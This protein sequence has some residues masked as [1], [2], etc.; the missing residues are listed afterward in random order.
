MRICGALLLALLYGFTAM[1]EESG[2]PPKIEPANPNLIPEAREV[3]D[4]LRLV[5]GTKTLAGINGF[6]NVEPIKA[7]CGKEPAICGFDLS[8]WNSPPWGPGYNKVV[9]SS[10]DSVKLWHAK[11]GIATMQCH[12]IH[13]SN[14]DGSAWLE[15]HGSKKPS[16]P[17][18]FA[19]ALKPGTKANQ[20]LMRDLKNH[21]DFL[22]QLK[23]AR[24]PVLWRPFHE[25]DGGWFW[26][27]DKENPENTAAAWRL[28]FDY[29]VKERKLDNLI[30]VYNCALRCGK[31]KEGI[32]NLE[33]RKRFYPGDPYVDIAGID[34]Y[35]SAYVGIG[36]PQEEAYAQSFATIRKLAPTKMVALSECEAT[37]DPDKIARDGPKWLYA[38]PWW[39][40]GKKHT[41]EWIKR[42]Y[43]HE[44]LITLDE[45]P[46]WKGTIQKA[47]E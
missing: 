46:K 8:G 18:A 20:E 17:F 28:M 35:P 16:Q 5:Y 30:W 2:P 32:E 36:T 41:E 21:A 1:G 31:G 45:L 10:I 23:E 9:Q 24:I 6:K 3:L 39:G 40:P 26:W 38:L 43:P 47:G 34:V 15:A 14:P 11:G 42:T 19:D 29:F 27:T 12:W 25:I 44:Q 22:A 7:I 33:Q 13:P 4:Y 37:P